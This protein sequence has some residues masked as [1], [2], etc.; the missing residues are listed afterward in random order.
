MIQR[1]VSVLY[2]RMYTP[3]YKRVIHR[4]V[5]HIPKMFDNCD[6]AGHAIL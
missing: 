5:D 2:I 3:R 4:L 1:K 6:D